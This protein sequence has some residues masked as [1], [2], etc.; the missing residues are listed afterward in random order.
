M[1]KVM[2]VASSGGH[3]VQLKRLESAFEG[4]E[5]VYVTTEE[6]YRSTISSGH[7]IV[8]PNAS[9]WNKLRS[10]YLAVLMFKHVM[11]VRPNVVVSTGAA[12]G[13]YALMFGKKF[14]AKTIWIDSIANVEQLSLSGRLVKNYADLWFTQWEHLATPK[15]P[16]YK[17]AV[18]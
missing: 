13:F 16:F 2:L 12:P 11:T 18:L 7:F 6:R 15:G 5:K 4:M 10:L 14:G 9:R 3:W 8:V 1:T 17:G